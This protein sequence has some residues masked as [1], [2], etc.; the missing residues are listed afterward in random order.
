MDSPPP[1]TPGKPPIIDAIQFRVDNLKHNGETATRDFAFRRWV[2]GT[3]RFSVVLESGFSESQTSEDLASERKAR[4]H[5]T[6][7]DVAAVISLMCCTT[8]CRNPA[9]SRPSV[10]PASLDDFKLAVAGSIGASFSGTSTLAS[11]PQELPL[12]CGSTAACVASDSCFSHPHTHNRLQPGSSSMFGLLQENGLCRIS[13]DSQGVT[14]NPYSWSSL[15]NM[16]YIDQ[17]RKL[18]AVFL[19][20][21]T[22]SATRSRSHAEGSIT[23]MVIATPYTAIT[24]SIT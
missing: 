17:A 12:S 22:G 24:G 11:S 4:M 18:S 21:N 10:P 9:S 20:P 3:S 23:Y 19:T 16:L 15:T 14:N 1:P 6:Q 2:P 7:P 8:A 13:N 5:L